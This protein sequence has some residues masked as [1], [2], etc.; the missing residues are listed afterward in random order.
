MFMDMKCIKTGCDII[1]NNILY[2]GDLM[3]RNGILIL[4]GVPNSS[5]QNVSC[6]KEMGYKTS[7]HFQCK[8]M[9]MIHGT[10]GQYFAFLVESPFDVQKNFLDQI[11]EWESPK[12]VALFEGSE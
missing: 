11:K 9:A 4:S 3:Y 2:H 6:L 7:Y 5:W 10:G 12:C 1:S 8:N